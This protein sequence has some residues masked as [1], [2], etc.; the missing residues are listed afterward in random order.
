MYKYG[1]LEFEWDETKEIYN[2]KKHGLN[3]G[4]SAESF[5]DPDGFELI[6]QEHSS[7]ELR[8]FWIGKN[9]TKD[10][11]ITTW[12]TRRHNKIRIIGAAEWRKFRKLYETTK[13]KKS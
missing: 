8:S 11:V 13:F 12:F 4:D 6:D 2:M 10:I 9:F 5:L 7:S 3:F 1:T